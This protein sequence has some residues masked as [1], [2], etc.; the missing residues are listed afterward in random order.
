MVYFDYGAAALLFVDLKSQTSVNTK[1]T[2]LDLV[3]DLCQ[4]I[5][6]I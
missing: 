1:L 6:K 5:Q 3:Q 4:Y 2:K